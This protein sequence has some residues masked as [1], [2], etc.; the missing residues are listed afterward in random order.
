[1]NDEENLSV[2]HLLNC[3]RGGDGGGDRR[4]ERLGSLVERGGRDIKSDKRNRGIGKRSLSFLLKKALLCGGGFAAAPPIIRDPLPDLKI[5]QST[6]EKI[7]RAMLHK[8]IYP[9]R[10]TTP[11]KCLDMGE[12]EEE[13]N[14]T[15]G[16]K[17]DKTDSEYIV[18]EI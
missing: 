9:Q 18:L 7:L 3:L 14:T 4:L 11:N 16:S 8:K 17:W 15:H 12:E 2:E 6:M 1:M 10:P 5:D 13:D